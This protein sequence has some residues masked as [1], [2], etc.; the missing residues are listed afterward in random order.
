MQLK[1]QES[2]PAMDDCFDTVVK[3]TLESLQH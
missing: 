1:Q 3:V 2:I